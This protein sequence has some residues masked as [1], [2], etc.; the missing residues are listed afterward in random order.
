MWSYLMNK[1][2]HKILRNRSCPWCWNAMNAEWWGCKCWLSVRLS[3]WWKSW[4][5]LFR[6]IRYCHECL[7]YAPIATPSWGRVGKNIYG[8]FYLYVVI[9]L[10]YASTINMNSWT[11]LYALFRIISGYFVQEYILLYISTF[12]EEM[13]VSIYKL[14]LL[15]NIAYIY[16]KG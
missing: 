3:C 15:M 9:M 4:T 8:L 2:L 13:Q 16:L 6:K 10:I 7:Y 12:K 5:M 11:N 14:E 1:S